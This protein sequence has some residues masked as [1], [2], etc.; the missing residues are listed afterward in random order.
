MSELKIK[1]F[2]CI[3]GE[4][5]AKRKRVGYGVGLLTLVAVLSLL[6]GCANG[7]TAENAVQES[8]SADT[9]EAA[10]ETQE[11]IQEGEENMNE[12]NFGL[13]Y[14]GAITENAP[15]QVNIHPVTYDLNGVTIAANVYT[16]ADY[17]PDGEKKYPAV[18]VAHPNGGVKEQVS[19]LFA[20]KLA[21]NG[22]IAI[23]ADAAYQG[24]SGG[25]PRNLDTP[26]NRVED[27]HGMVDYLVNFPGVDAERIGL[28]GICGGGGYTIKAAQTEKRAKAVA[29]LSMFNTGIVRL[30]GLGNSQMDTIQERIKEAADARTEEA[31][32]GKVVYPAPRGEITQEYI[33]SLPDGLY[34][35]GMYYYGRD[36][37]HPNAGG[38]VPVKCL[39]DLVDF[40]ARHN[41]ELI[42][43]PLLMMA[44]S[45]ADTLYM[46]EDCFE[47]ATGTNDKELFIIE[48][49]RHIETYFKQ[50]YVEQETEKLLAFFGK[51]L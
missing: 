10:M 28:F 36:Y 45:E 31:R 2:S 23:A 32:T 7:G 4:S 17:A 22:Y 37:A 16:P 20:Q 29:T 48:G 46:T 49:A 40:D 19:G 27:V 41:M 35:D 50:P 14:D 6:S 34:K 3:A 13:V 25:E 47:L 1:R 44:G 42:T 21:E 5:G 51:N 12:V 26:A 33:D 38:Q 18:T 11:P 43:Q 24:A 9:Q 15:G 30:Y 39:L 8:K